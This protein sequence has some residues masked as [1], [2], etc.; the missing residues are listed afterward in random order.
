MEPA[1]LGSINLPP[2]DSQ[3][4]LVG[5]SD[6]NSIEE[7]ENVCEVPRRSSRVTKVQWITVLILCYIR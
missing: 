1:T 5:N 6:C 2:N 7:S 3:H 4:Q